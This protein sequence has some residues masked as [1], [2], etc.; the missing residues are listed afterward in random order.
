MQELNQKRKQNQE[1]EHCYP[2]QWLAK[3]QEASVDLVIFV[4][5]VEEPKQGSGLRVQLFAVEKTNF[6]QYPRK[7]TQRNIKIKQLIPQKR[8][9]YKNSKETKKKPTKTP[10]KLKAKQTFKELGTPWSFSAEL[11]ASPLPPSPKVSEVSKRQT[12]LPGKTPKNLKKT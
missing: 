8:N 1:T 11:V 5:K 10:T 3:G 12:T 9:S 4:P 2:L 7:I 6:I